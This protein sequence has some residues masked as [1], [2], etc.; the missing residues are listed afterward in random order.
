MPLDESDTPDSVDQL[1]YPYGHL[2]LL[3]LPLSVALVTV[4]VWIVVL[5]D[6]PLLTE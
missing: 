5:Q 4:L 1:E 6:S 2:F 3:V